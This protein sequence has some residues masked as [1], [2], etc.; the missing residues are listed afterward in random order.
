MNDRST[1]KGNMEIKTSSIRSK[2]AAKTKKLILDAA[3]NLFIKKG[4]EGVSIS[5]IAKKAGT[6]SSL[7][8]HYFESK[9]ELWK[10]VKDDFVNAFID[11][12]N[13]KFDSSKGL[14][15][16]IK[17]IVQTRVSFY[18]KHPEVMR[19]IGWQRLETSKNKLV[20]GSPFSPDQWKKCF[21]ELQAL[22]EI[23]KEIDVDM[24]ILFV[25][26]LISGMFTEDYLSLL[27]F[28]KKKTEYLSTIINS[29]IQTF[30]N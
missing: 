14:E 30:G 19:M 15:N 5:E 17:Q 1:K 23:R 24:M 2:A 16:I 25:S 28:E 12:E 10:S 27:K 6:N 4:F 13:L 18:E 3:S 29:I 26:S 20:G 21:M 8:Y 22:G 9:E 7:I 11:K